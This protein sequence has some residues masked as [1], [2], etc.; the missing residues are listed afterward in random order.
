[1][2]IAPKKWDRRIILDKD[3]SRDT[4][5]LTINK[6]SARDS[7]DYKVAAKNRQGDCSVTVSVTVGKPKVPKTVAPKATGSKAAKPTASKIPKAKV[8]AAKVPKPK[9]TDAAKKPEPDLEVPKD[10]ESRSESPKAVDFSKT[11][12]VIEETVMDGKVVDTAVSEKTTGEMKA[13]VSEIKLGTKMA[14]EKLEVIEEVTTEIPPAEERGV[15]GAGAKTKLTSA[16]EEL[17]VQ[18]H[19]EEVKKTVT[20]AGVSSPSESEDDGSSPKITQPPESQFVDVGATIKLTCKVS[21]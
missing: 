6:A 2:V 10:V 16:K 5:T 11:V 13:G 17:P 3:L 20:L 7:G 19:G 21:G 9:A 15:K 14:D 4:Y 8:P 12:T 1:M 18:L